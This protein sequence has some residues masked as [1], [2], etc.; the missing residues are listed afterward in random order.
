VKDLKYKPKYE[1][2]KD[3]LLSQVIE[4]LAPRQQVPTQRALMHDYGLSYATVTRGLKDLEHDGYIYRIQGKGT[5]KSDEGMLRGGDG[6]SYEMPKVSKATTDIWVI[7]F[8]VADNTNYTVEFLR[9]IDSSCAMHG[10]NIHV[11]T[12]KTKSIVREESSPVKQL[13]TSGYIDGVILISPFA[14]MDIDALYRQKTPFVVFNYEYRN[15]QNIPRVMIDNREAVKRIVEYL[16]SNGHM[17]I[18]AILGPLARK[19]STIIIS[20]NEML[21]ALKEYSLDNGVRL[22][23]KLV[24]NGPYKHGE[25]MMDDILDSGDRP[26]A[27]FIDGDIIYQGAIKSVLAHNLDPEK[28]ILLVNYADNPNLA[29][30]AGICKPLFDSGETAVKM[31]ASMISHPNEEMPAEVR[32]KPS[33]VGLD[34]ELLHG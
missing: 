15:L 32:V 4:K 6:A 9:G 34:G 8:G 22:N 10:F 27:V 11:Y 5:F 17:D 2:F 29:G 26:S 1:Y 18:G 16:A 31:L 3:I 14:E 19:Y 25:K 33:H 23:K 20:P 30:K 21:A 24:K 7:F 28:D 13:L 12:T